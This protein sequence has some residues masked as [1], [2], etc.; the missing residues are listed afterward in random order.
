MKDLYFLRTDQPNKMSHKTVVSN[1]QKKGWDELV[2]YVKAGAQGELRSKWVSAP[3]GLHAPRQCHW[4]DC[5][6]HAERTKPSCWFTDVSFLLR[7]DGDGRARGPERGAQ[8]GP[9]VP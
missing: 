6:V 9:L 4:S 3:G 1:F 8:G 7:Q 2:N 5:D